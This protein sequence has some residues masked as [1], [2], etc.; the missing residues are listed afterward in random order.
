ME[1]SQTLIQIGV[2]AVVVGLILRRT[3][4]AQTMR[5][6]ALPV[7]A[8]FFVLIGGFAI[9]NTPQTPGEWIAVPIGAVFGAGLGYLRGR[10]STVT[11][12]TKPGTI[13]VKGSPLLA[14]IILAALAV[15]AGIRSLM[16]GHSAAAFAIADGTIAFAVLSVAVAR[17][18]L[19][20][21]ARRTAA[22]VS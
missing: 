7:V 12:G 13:R 16:P 9:A 14:G 1:N 4:T 3:L 2:Y 5:V 11:A 22:P 8:V 20:F 21:A 19:Y 17:L 18:M 6:G 15:R 10:H